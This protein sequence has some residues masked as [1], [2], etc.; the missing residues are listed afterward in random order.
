MYLDKF[1]WLVTFCWCD[2]SLD[3]LRLFHHTSETTSCCVYARTWKEIRQPEFFHDRAAAS[4]AIRHRTRT[5]EGCELLLSQTCTSWSSQS[6]MLIIV[7]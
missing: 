1:C 4:V 5:S 3:I 7:S 6:P 2:V